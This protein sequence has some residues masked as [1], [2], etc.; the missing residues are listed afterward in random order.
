MIKVL[1]SIEVSPGAT[2]KVQTNQGAVLV[3]NNSTQTLEF[4]CG[5]TFPPGLKYKKMVMA[6]NGNILYLPAVATDCNPL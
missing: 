5:E 4:A 3:T 1:K 6:S 2:C